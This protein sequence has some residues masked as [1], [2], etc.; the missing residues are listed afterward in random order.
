MSEISDKMMSEQMMSPHITNALW[1]E[2]AQQ[3]I[4]KLYE[5][6]IFPK[7]LVRSVSDVHAFQGWRIEPV[8]PVEAMYEQVLRKGDEITLD[9][10]Q[11]LVGY[12]TLSLLNVRSNADAPLRLK[13]T[14][15]EM[16]CE[17][18]EDFATYEGWLS[19]SWLQ[20]EIV[21]VDVLPGTITLD[22]RYAFRYL[23]LEVLETSIR[24]DLQLK[25]V[26]CTTVTSASMAA[27]APL[28]AST[29]Q[30][31]VQLDQISIHTLRDCMQ[32]VFEDGPKRDRRLWIGDLRLQALVNYE[33]F[34]RNDLVKRC[35]YLFAGSRL[36]GGQVGACL[37]EKP[38]PYVDDIYLYDYSL[39][40]ITTLWDYYEA[41]KDRD[42][43]EALWP[44]A[45]EQMDIALKRLD[46]R[47][48]VQD[49]ETWY[50]FLDWHEQLNKQA[51]AQAVLIY[52]MKRG[53]CIARELGLTEHEQQ[54]QAQIRLAE[55]AALRFLWDEE[56]GF[57][58]SG[59][60]RQVSWAS[61]V[62]MILAEVV[63]V[64]VARAL[65]QR[66]KGYNEAIP[67]NTP[68]MM[69]HYVE[70]LLQC[71]QKEDALEQIRTYWGGMIKDGADTFW[72][73]YNPEDKT[74]S[75]YGSNL[76]NSYCHAWSCTPS[77]F[78]RR[79]FAVTDS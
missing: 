77:Y 79:H 43:L 17:I 36:E 37:Y 62:W 72:E 76:I 10:G 50:C 53:L 7:Q 22:R 32:T 27:V 18:G 1:M 59:E 70:A 69:H 25:D 16:P 31:L 54:I 78:I 75:P 73:L 9:F 30:E 4:P 34:G 44:V 45:R 42:T 28:P 12:V 26:F 52:G 47:G 38:Q 51:G 64:E 29:D 56:Q 57:F 41:T 5:Q 19:R 68:Y 58:I 39:F 21:N 66:L 2:Q 65:L 55:E 71:G 63:D 11:H 67:M 60:Q 61:Q 23:K 74:Y 13:L 48:I 24:Y 14:F 3:W 33:T 15:G 46:A 8:A 20:D 40:F 6:K 49:D 35:L